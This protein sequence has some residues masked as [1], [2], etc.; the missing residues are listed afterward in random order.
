MLLIHKRFTPPPPLFPLVRQ[1][2]LAAM[3]QKTVMGDVAVDGVKR[4]LGRMLG[5]DFDTCDAADPIAK[6]QRTDFVGVP[7]PVADNTIDSAWGIIHD[8]VVQCAPAG[9]DR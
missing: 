5:V 7:E 3:S 8:A 9:T 2:L 6:R 1:S 4:V